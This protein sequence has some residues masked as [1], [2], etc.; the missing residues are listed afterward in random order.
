MER[1]IATLTENF[2]LPE[3]FSSKLCEFEEYT[4]AQNVSLQIHIP[5]GSKGKHIRF[6][7]KDD[8]KEI[9]LA[10]DAVSLY[11]PK[12]SLRV[13]GQ[14]HYGVDI[15]ELIEIPMSEYDTITVPYRPFDHFDIV[16]LHDAEDVIM[17]ANLRAVTEELPQDILNGFTVMKLP[18]FPIGEISVEAGAHKITLPD[19]TNIVEGAV[20]EIGNHTYQIKA[21]IGN[22]ATLD[23]SE[24]GDRILED[25]SGEIFMKC[26]IRIGYYDQNLKLPSVI[27]WYSSPTPDLRAIRREEYRV[28]GN[29]VYIKEKTQYA[30]WGVRIEVVGGSPEMIQLVASYVRKFLEKNRV[31]INGKRFTFEWTD[32][33]VDTE[34]S[35]YL[36]IE[37][38]VAYNLDIT[39]QEEFLWQ[40]I[41][42]GSARLRNVIPMQEI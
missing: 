11:C 24:D 14:A 23:H 32:S 28:F 33:A 5:A 30:Q 37:P 8:G 20:L 4:G 42:K 38:S 7:I 36:E 25:F 22:V 15:G 2:I 19:I 21:L 6:D 34:P 17:I 12:N 39:L 40:T 13:S 3:R 16:V 35:S 18:H 41:Q 1:K 31:F 29:E 26:P 9:D 10:F 27:L